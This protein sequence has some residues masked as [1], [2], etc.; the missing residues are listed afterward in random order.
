[1]AMDRNMQNDP[2]DIDHSIRLQP[3]DERAVHA[4]RR[5]PWPPAVSPPRDRGLGRVV[6]FLV[7]GGG[8]LLAVGAIAA[9]VGIIVRL[10]TDST[11]NVVVTRQSDPAS[12]RAESTSVF[13]A[14]DAVEQT[15]ADLDDALKRERAA[16]DELFS[17]L[18]KCAAQ[19][20]H[21]EFKRLVDFDRMMKRVEGTGHM[22][23]WTS[24][25]KRS[26][27]GQIK[28]MAEAESYWGEITVAGIVTPY[29]D[30]NTRIV[31]A[32]CYDSA[33]DSPSES[34]FWIARDGD[35]WK[36][37]DWA[38]LDLGLAESQEW[39][40][41][42]KYADTPMLAGF[43]RWGVLIGEADEAI[44]RGDREAAKEKLRRAES[45]IVPPELQ[46]FHWVLTGF[47]WFALDETKEA[48]RCYN[49]VS[50]PADTPGAYYGLLTSHRWK[51]PAEAFKY[52]E[53]YE[54]AVGPC[55]QLLETKA[56]LLRRLGRDEES[57][58]EWRR[59][60]R[61]KPDHA[62]AMSEFVSSLS[63]ENESEFE[64]QLEQLN[65]PMASAVSIAR[66]VGDQDYE[67]LLL[68]AG[69]VNRKSPDS[70]ASLYVSGL[71]QFLDGRY[72]EAAELYRLASEKE[73]HESK[74]ES[75]VN[76]YIEAMAADGKVIE[77]LKKTPNAKSALEQLYYNYE[78]E[79]LELTNDEYR[80]V[81]LLH[82]R[83]SPDDL[84]AM[85][86][87]AS[88][89]VTEERYADAERVLRK[90]LQTHPAAAED[91]ESD[92]DYYR[93]ACEALL[94]TALYR[95]DRW[96]EA[97]ENVGER[98][99]RFAHLSR[100]AVEEGRWDVVRKLLEIHRAADA[101]DP[102]LH[103]VEAELAA[104]E[105]QWDDAVRHLRQ[106]LVDSVDYESWQLKHQL[107]EAYVNSGRWL[108][109]FKTSDDQGETF[110][111]LANRFVADENWNAM[112]ELIAEYRRTAP[113]DIR[114][115]Q[116]EA[117]IAWHQEKYGMY[118]QLARQLLH[119]DNEE[120]LGYERIEI[121]N[122]LMSALLRSRLF[123]QAWQ[124][125]LTKQREENNVSKMAIVNAANG[126]LPEA[127]RLAIEAARE[128]EQAVTFYSDSDTAPV[129]LGD[130]F[131]ELHDEFPVNVPYDATSTLAVFVFDEPQRLEAE[132]IYAAMKKL[133]IEI[134]AAVEPITSARPGAADAY[135]LKQ[136]N[137]TVWLAAGEGPF[138]KSWRLENKQHP[139]AGALDRGAGWLAVGTAALTESDRKRVEQTARRLG[140]ELVGDRAAAVCI[141]DRQSWELA[142]YPAKAELIAEWHS[143][144]KVKS[145]KD[146]AAPLMNVP[147][148]DLAASREFQRALRAAVRAFEASPGARLEVVSCI[149]TSAQIDPLRLQVKKVRRSY[150]S[151]EFEGILLNDSALVPELHTG[152]PMEFGSN[153]IQEVRLNDDEPVRRR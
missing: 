137:A 101:E 22:A 69:Y 142:A 139:L 19:S 43:E 41:Y 152:L 148:E 116:Q 63:I 133:G 53:L 16:I 39:G 70:P 126:N 4:S 35:S 31:Y 36:L 13:G 10:G 40:L 15:R 38:R 1:M 129:F 30:P 52:A 127:R 78:E 6:V 58:K 110:E 61:I 83:L 150:G 82:R 153:F 49:S 104:H 96:Q 7:I 79:G 103:G 146:E 87:E 25:D 54:T 81:V 34:R 60:L 62:Y 55:P 151:L 37:Y 50:Q 59:L 76:D 68:I 44:N 9:A 29:D 105:K 143:T 2:H 72:A 98:R 85:H 20:T 125:A 8:V 75:Y 74:R 80:Q 135:G 94:A 64:S 45:E 91:P 5:E 32:Y 95:L 26:W 48:E 99:D 114:I 140:A 17:Q 138:E 128:Q 24:F 57:A 109:H 92:E 108:D 136:G 23:G 51:Q 130:E 18:E 118:A 28:A 93:N 145:F 123:G 106:G 117:Q 47:R 56:Q 102:H 66:T 33:S 141:G 120:I 115:V 3:A 149:S 46:D 112:T 124:L 12:L 134:G 89:A 100:M 144:G 88:L 11:K 73:T 107:M 132:T 21:D 86:R 113:D 14:Y 42:A 27:R 147:A 122:R 97:Y 111:R 67:R 77:A 71:T 65:D 84:D 119:D 131:S 90:A 121:E